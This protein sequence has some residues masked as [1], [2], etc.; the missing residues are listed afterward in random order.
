M[1][2]HRYCIRLMTIFIS[3]LVVAGH[4][5]L[6]TAQ[7]PNS[8]FDE[9]LDQAVKNF[10]EN[11]TIP[12]AAVGIVKDGKLI[13]AKGH[14]VRS[15]ERQE[16][17]EPNTLF[18]IG[19]ITKVFTTTLL[20]KLRDEGLVGLDDPVEKYLPKN[21]AVPSW[22]NGDE[23]V[24][25]TLRHLATHGAGFP[26]NPP[27]RRNRPNSPSVMEPYSIAELYKG[28]AKTKLVFKPGTSWQYSNYGF[29]VLGHAL[30]RT[31]GRPYEELL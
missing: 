15:L 16:P 5:H 25:P 2:I 11:N 23:V 18:Q 10:L 29:G 14:G 3:C 4:A 8:A 31:A 30:E 9:A 26:P 7:E 13:Y 28:L 12:G 22:K 17:V 21:A 6:V 24:A 27:N 1:S 20:M 19:S